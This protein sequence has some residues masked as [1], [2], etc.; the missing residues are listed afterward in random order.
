MR[1]WYDPSGGE[2]GKNTATWFAQHVGLT[3]PT[4]YTFH[5][6]PPP[7][8]IAQRLPQ[9]P[10]LLELLPVIRHGRADLIVQVDENDENLAGEENQI[11]LVVEVTAEAPHGHNFYQRSEKVVPSA[12]LGIP[13]AYIL[14][15]CKADA[16]GRI[17][18]PQSYQ[19]SVFGMFHHR[20]D[21]PVMHVQ[22]PATDQGDLLI[23]PTPAWQPASGYQGEPCVD[24]QVLTFINQCR[25]Y[26]VNGQ[27]VNQA[28]AGA[29]ATNQ[30]DFITYQNEHE[31]GDGWKG[32]R[33]LQVTSPANVGANAHADVLRRQSTLVLGPVS[34]GSPAPN[35]MRI[36]PYTGTAMWAEEW[37]S[38]SLDGQ[39][40]CNTVY[41]SSN[42]QIQ[43]WND[44]IADYMNVHDE[45][46]DCPFH[47]TAA[48]TPQTAAYHMLAEDPCC[49]FN[50]A[51]THSKW[52]TMPHAVIFPDGVW[53]SPYRR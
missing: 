46:V 23:D 30:A 15:Q 39:L 44:L 25:D 45:N 40:E 3:Y 34:L 9:T 43:T 1:L 49:P 41:Q 13:T 52:L 38:R 53:T 21:T 14:P 47:N 27:P 10:G 50:N 31:R 32:H 12:S 5:V 6:I 18:R 42:G 29:I 35:F 19:S 4:D 8:Q 22:W 11:I 51:Y 2:S 7:Q 24:G 28:F 33:T 16:Q 37:I 17:Y 20:Y 26:L 36:D 48:F